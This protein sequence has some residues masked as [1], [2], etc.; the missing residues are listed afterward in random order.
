MTLVRAL[1]S[2]LPRGR[3]WRYAQLHARRLELGPGQEW[4]RVVR[5]E[6]DTRL[7]TAWH[8]AGHACYAYLRRLPTSWVTIVPTVDYDGCTEAPIGER[9]QLARL[10]PTPAAITAEL[11]MA[12]A[13]AVAEQLYNVRIPWVDALSGKDQS[14]AFH[15]ACRLRLNV[16]DAWPTVL[17]VRDCVRR[18]FDRPVARTA[19]AAL[20]A[21][22]LIRETMSPTEVRDVLEGAELRRPGR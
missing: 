20:A 1:R 6:D 12:V 7:R 4:A 2:I 16:A 14:D 9:A 17:E 5:V 19:L 15:H 13:G 18:L 8:E 10:A 21:Q 11:G 22:L 3:P